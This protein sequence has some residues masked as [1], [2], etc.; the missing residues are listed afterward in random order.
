M[1]Y[2]KILFLAAFLVLIGCQN[3]NK[4]SSDLNKKSAKI[5]TSEKFNQFNIRFH[6]DS[7]FQ[8]SRIDFPIEG[9][10]VSGF[11]RHKWTKENWEFMIIPVSEKNTIDEYEHSLI[12]NDSLVIERFWIPDSGF[13][14]E[15][16]FK[17]IRNKWFLVYYNDINL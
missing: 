5:E 10:S 15:R 9:L 14:V 13:E 8:I 3:K 11:D 17:L 7:I 16:Q 12:K 2:S 1:R 4:K 6:S